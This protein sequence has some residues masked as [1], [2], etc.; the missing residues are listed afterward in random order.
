MPTSSPDISPATRVQLDTLG[1]TLRA[2]RKALGLSAVVLAEAAGMSRPTL[3]RI[4]RGEASVTIGAWAAALQALGLKLSAEPDSGQSPAP[5]TDDLS[6][7]ARIRLLDYPG[8]QALAWQLKQAEFVSPTEAL[9]LYE[10]NWRH[11][12][13]ASLEPAERDLIAALRLAFTRDSADV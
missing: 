11:L 3:H 9:E 10:R 8:L 1:A 5:R 4:E 6:V 13:P 2:R 7:P 12:D